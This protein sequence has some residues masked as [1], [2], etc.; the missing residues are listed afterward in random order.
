M[1]I[2]L[3]PRPKAFE[4]KI[5]GIGAGNSLVVD[6]SRAVSEF[7]DSVALQQQGIQAGLPRYLATRPMSALGHK[8]TFRNVRAMSALPPKADILGTSPV[9]LRRTNSGSFATLAAIRRL[10]E[11]ML[12]WRT[13]V[14]RL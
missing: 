6:K 13:P 9:Q 11:K 7:L 3:S 2:S 12:S 10:A 14:C 8:R 1:S 4:Q 5:A